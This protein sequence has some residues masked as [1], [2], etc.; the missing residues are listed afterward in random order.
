MYGI[1]WDDRLKTGNEQV[2]EQHK[3]L[4][5]L[6]GNLV[7]QCI[8]GN[9]TERLK[10]TLDFLVGYTVQHFYDEESIQVQYNYPEYT[11]HKRLH[12]DFKIVVGG[13]VQ[14]F[15][16]GGSTS[17]LSNDVN[18]IIVRWLVGHIQQEDKKIVKH[19]RRVSAQP[20]IML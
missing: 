6:L 18:K 15:N 12:E 9:N 20:L 13:L 7:G 2:D 4:F 17:E 10:E 1:A 11:A 3:C 14:R 16:D 8:D 19:I 5:D